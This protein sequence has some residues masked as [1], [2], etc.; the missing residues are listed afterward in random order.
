[1]SVLCLCIFLFLV[2][3]FS[4]SCQTDKVP[5]RVNMLTLS[6]AL[7]S[8]CGW[9]GLVL[10]TASLIIC[11]SCLCPS[12]FL[13]LLFN[14]PLP[15]P[16]HWKYWQLKILSVHS[17]TESLSIV[18]KYG[19][20]A[21]LVSTVLHQQDTDVGLEIDG[22]PW[23]CSP[24]SFRQRYTAHLAKSLR[25]VCAVANSFPMSTDLLK[26]PCCLSAVPFLTCRA[27]A[28]CDLPVIYNDK[29]TSRAT[30]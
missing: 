14:I 11:Q 2:L 10:I 7:I 19:N 28:V 29:D 26:T 17:G 23:L 13:S 18:V 16:V 24:H 25:C 6:C 3:P 22:G 9:P 5:D 27:V 30:L 15:L 4:L 8:Q 21:C 12:M 1:M 20:S